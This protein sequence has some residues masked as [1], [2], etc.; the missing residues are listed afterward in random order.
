MG[1]TNSVQP[2][3]MLDSMTVHAII[4][5]NWTQRLMGVSA[6][7]RVMGFDPRLVGKIRKGSGNATCTVRHV[8]QR[9]SHLHAGERA[10]KH[11]VVKT[12]E[13]ADAE[14]AARKLTQ[15]GSE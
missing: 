10:R 14:D 8:E 3:C 7:D 11:Q 4:R 1:L 9:E 2:Y 13:V 15:A 5:P 6:G 12:A